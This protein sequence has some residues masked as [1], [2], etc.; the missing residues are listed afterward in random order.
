MTTVQIQNTPNRVQPRALKNNDGGDSPKPPQEPKNPSPIADFYD[1]YQTPI[2]LAG[3]A[4]LGAGLAKVCG[5]PSESI[6]SAAGTGA[7]AGFFAGSPKKA[8]LM[9]GGAAVGAAIATMAGVPPA[10]VLGAAGTGT[11]VAFIFG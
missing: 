10:G 7:F 5:L 2:H 9:A 3:G 11:L 4:L 6:M 8:A 1:S